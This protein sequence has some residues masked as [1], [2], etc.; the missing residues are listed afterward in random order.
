MIEHKNDLN[1]FTYG[2]YSWR[3]PKNWFSNIKNF[4]RSIIRAWQRATKGYCDYYV[5]ILANAL[6]LLM[7]K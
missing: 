5:N 6:F 3:Y 7:T 2:Y 4:F 1:V